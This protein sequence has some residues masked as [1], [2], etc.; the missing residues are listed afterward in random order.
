MAGS[1][2]RLWTRERVGYAAA[3]APR[4]SRRGAAV[5]AARLQTLRGVLADQQAAAPEDDEGSEG[6]DGEDEVP[7]SGGGSEASDLS[8]ADSQDFAYPSG[9]AFEAPAQ[10]EAGPTADARGQPEAERPAADS[11]P[12]TAPFTP[13][14]QPRLLPRRPVRGGAHLVR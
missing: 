8:T 5:P 4:A 1:P 11:Q 7:E 9:L 3:I 14:Q 2:A 10:A 6:A 13:A 12:E